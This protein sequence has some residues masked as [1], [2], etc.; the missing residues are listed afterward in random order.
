MGGKKEGGRGAAISNALKGEG[1]RLVRA[2]NAITR[3]AV[4]ERVRNCLLTSAPPILPIQQP[5]A[6]PGGFLKPRQILRIV[7]TQLRL[8]IWDLILSMYPLSQIL[9]LSVADTR[10]RIP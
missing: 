1:R 8:V 5:A 3:V 6:N 2:D 10:T 4:Q 9:V 7:C